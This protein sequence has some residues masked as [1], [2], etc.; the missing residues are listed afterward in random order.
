MRRTR[1]RP[2]PPAAE[3]RAFY[4]TCVDGGRNA[5]LAGP[6]ATH[7]EALDQVDPARAAADKATRGWSH[8]Y[9]FGTASLPASDPTLPV[10]RL[11]DELGIIPATAFHETG[12]APAAKPWA[13]G[14]AALLRAHGKT[15]ERKGWLS[16][17]GHVRK[18]N[19]ARKERLIQG[20]FGPHHEVYH[21]LPCVVCSP[22][23][24]ADRLAMLRTV[25][26]Y[27]GRTWRTSDPAHVRAKGAG[28]K[29]RAILPACRTH[30][31]LERAWKSGAPDIEGAR[32]A[33]EA[34]LAKAADLA[35]VLAI[36]APA[37]DL[38]AGVYELAGGGTPWG[39]ALRLP[40]VLAD[41]DLRALKACPERYRAIAA[42][43][44]AWAAVAC[45]WALALPQAD[46][47]DGTT[48]TPEGE[49]E[50]SAG[51]RWFPA[52]R[53]AGPAAGRP[54]MAGAA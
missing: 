50:A 36:P 21:V 3:A 23:A 6:F 33:R 14:R 43:I 13:S 2:P 53:G 24:Y 18:V 38:A 49:G 8:F 45:P 31:N 12:P 39:F 34:G 51:A 40:A 17:K 37:F 54:A 32:A 10:G 46:G 25:E 30:H 28:G 19:P 48:D 11:N 26:R 22:E 9:A 35:A 44:R 47:D 16:R 42:E 52:K 15:L 7:Q 4:V 29:H 41:L 20:Q 27:H 1:L 5:W